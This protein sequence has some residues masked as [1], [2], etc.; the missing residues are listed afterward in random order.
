MKFKYAKELKK[1]FCVTG[2][3][4]KLQAP[5]GIY[6]CR[7]LLEIKRSN[8]S[9]EC[10][11]LVIM[12]NPGSS[13]PKEAGIAEEVLSA[14]DVA[15]ISNIKSVEAKP[16][17]TQ[18]QIMRI[19]LE[20]DYSHAKVLNLFDIRN[21]SSSDFL[22]KKWPDE[23]SIFSEVRAIELQ[24]YLREKIPVILACGKVNQIQDKV[25]AVERALKNSLA[26]VYFVKAE[27]GYYRHPSPP[28]QK[29]KQKWLDDLS[30]S[31]SAGDT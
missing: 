10:D 30:N 25:N 23:T 16:D 20:F 22:S 15:S 13:R 9:E 24:K 1:I 17:P 5:D 31:I 8:S 21:T 7:N 14:E 4:Y 2:S 6:A 19:M 29:L 27:G 18:Y 3:Y 26:T 28:N 11:L 12:M